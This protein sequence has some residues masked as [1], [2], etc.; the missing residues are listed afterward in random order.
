MAPA[1]SLAADAGTENPPH[2][3]P[4]LIVAG[5]SYWLMRYNFRNSA[6]FRA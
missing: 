4:I 1:S 5:F 6:P 2:H 3:F